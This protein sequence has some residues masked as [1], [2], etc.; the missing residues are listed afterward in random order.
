MTLVSLFSCFSEGSDLVDGTWTLG[1]G[2]FMEQVWAKVLD[3]GLVNVME[4]NLRIFNWV[5]FPLLLS[6]A[7]RG[8]AESWIIW[9]FE[10]NLAS[11]IFLSWVT[12]SGTTLNIY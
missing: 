5:A 11:F 3:T 2:W 1:S 10:W 12:F 6:G 4:P 8:K 9:S 7:G